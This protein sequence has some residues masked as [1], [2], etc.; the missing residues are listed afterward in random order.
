MP[1]IN[2]LKKG[3]S[4]YQNVFPKKFHNK[5]VKFIFKLNRVLMVFYEVKNISK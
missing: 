3:L 2:F 4:Y 1:K 5:Y